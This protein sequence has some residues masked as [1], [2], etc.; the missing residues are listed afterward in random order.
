MRG[1]RLIRTKFRTAK[2]GV[3]SAK[4][5][6]AFSTQEPVGAAGSPLGDCGSFVPFCD[7]VKLVAEAA[8]AWPEASA[9]NRT[10]LS[11]LSQAATSSPDGSNPWADTIARMFSSLSVRRTPVGE[12]AHLQLQADQRRLLKNVHL[13]SQK[14]LVSN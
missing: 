8:S 12:K 10:Q 4:R 14:H 13:W 11:C 5:A 7:D 3:G 6:V 2:V 1:V 9:A